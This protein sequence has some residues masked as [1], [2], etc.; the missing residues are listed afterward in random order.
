M[1][2]LAIDLKVANLAELCIDGTRVL[3]DAHQYK[4]WT[5]QK[6]TRAL[7]QLAGYRETTDSDSC[8][9]GKSLPHRITS[10]IG[11]PIERKVYT[12]QDCAGCPLAPQCVRKSDAD[13]REVIDDVH[14]AARRRHRVKMQSEPSQ[15]AYRCLTCVVSCCEASQGWAKSGSGWQHGFQFE[16]VDAVVGDTAHVGNRDR[17]CCNSR[18]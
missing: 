2:K 17:Q 4:T 7:E 14:E 5:T 13:G 8:P 12:C 11:A 15:T 16:K 18:G 1:V 6:L 10:S 9:A 3:A